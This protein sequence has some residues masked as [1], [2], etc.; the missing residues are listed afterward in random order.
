MQ[1]DLRFVRENTLVPV[2]LLGEL[3]RWFEQEPVP[4]S[5]T[6][7][8]VFKLQH[9]EGRST[10]GRAERRVRKILRRSERACWK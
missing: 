6:F 9:V 3:G 5:T 10:V 2:A 4:S 1:A 8:A 7:P